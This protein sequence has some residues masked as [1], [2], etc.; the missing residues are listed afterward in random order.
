MLTSLWRARCHRHL[1]YIPVWKNLD[2][3][4]GINFYVLSN[5]AQKQLDALKDPEFLKDVRNFFG[6]DEDAE[7]V[8]ER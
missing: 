1:A 7:F 3:Y 6:L 4:E 2:G 8:W 5:K